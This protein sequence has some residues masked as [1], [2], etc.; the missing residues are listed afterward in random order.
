[1]Q[2]AS[3]TWTSQTLSIDS[4]LAAT[5]TTESVVINASHISS[6]SSSDSSLIWVGGR[7]LKWRLVGVNVWDAS[8]YSLNKEQDPYS[9][10]QAIQMQRWEEALTLFSL[11][12]LGLLRPGGINLSPPM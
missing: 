10:W 4:G 1:M 5:A 12:F 3:T 2:V 8:W 6:S 9:T 7:T 11:G